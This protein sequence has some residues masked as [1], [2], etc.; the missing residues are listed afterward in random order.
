MRPTGSAVIGVFGCPT[1]VNNVETLAALPWIVHNGADA[2]AAIGTDKS[3]GTMLFSISGMVEHPGVY[4]GEFGV[5]LWEFIEQSTGGV[6]GGKKLKAVIPGGSS[7]AILTAD[8][9]RSVKLD[10]ESIA[11]AGSMVR[12]NSMRLSSLQSPPNSRRP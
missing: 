2:Y 7:A 9:A 11:A 8:E 12:L 6:K 3:K 10:Y 4:E 1:V 5:N